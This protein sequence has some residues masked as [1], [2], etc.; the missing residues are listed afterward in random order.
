MADPVEALEQQAACLR[1]QADA[2]EALAGTLREG[3]GPST[4]VA[5]LTVSEIA[6]ELGKSESAVR[7]WLPIPGAYK[8]GDQWRIPRPAWRR[9]L[10]SLAEKE[11]TADDSESSPT[12][13]SAWREEAAGGGR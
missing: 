10:D 13:L 7:S 4:A 3:S 8:L 11:F 6:E 5:D 2:L 1:A 9:Y 12:D